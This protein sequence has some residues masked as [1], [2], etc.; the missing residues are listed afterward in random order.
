MSDDNNLTN[1]RNVL[2]F[3]LAGFGA[4]LTFLGV[5]SSEVTTILRNNSP[6][7][8][9][10]AFILLLGV[11]AAVWAVATDGKKK[12]NPASAVAIVFIILGTGALTIFFIP[13][14]LDPF[15]VSG[16]ISLVIGCVG[17]A[18]G[19][20]E[21]IGSRSFLTER[22]MDLVDFLILTSVLLI[23]IAAYG[24]MRLESK[25]QL[26]FSS[27][28]GATFSVNGSSATVSVDI[29]AT[30]LAQNDW[31]FVD[32]YAV[33]VGTSLVEMCADYVVPANVPN[34][35]SQ[36]AAPL[37]E[38][39]TNHCTT[40]PCVYFFA[41]N[42]NGWPNVCD[43]L[44]NGSVVPNAAGDVDETLSV[45]FKIAL[46]EDVDVRAEVCQPNNGVCEGSVSRQNSRLDW[47][48]SQPQ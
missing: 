37:V 32:V 25:S 42:Y 16:T 9:L 15:T 21:L 47:V 18:A 24:G 12:V 35:K 38:Y 30:K 44:L 45:P 33:P 46:Y 28:V 6:Q 19:T 22:G 43:V 8:S 36:K 7:A 17:I 13:T 40:D 23:A 4:I 20:L 2:G 11:L 48:I 5:R 27:Q 1:I 39:Y 3:L 26:S 14:G 31:I 34:Y 10:I 41:G 29:A